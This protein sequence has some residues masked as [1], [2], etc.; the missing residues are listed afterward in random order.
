VA[1]IDLVMHAGDHRALDPA[2]RPDPAG[3]GDDR[4]ALDL[5]DHAEDE[6]EVFE[7]LGDRRE[8]DGGRAADIGED[9][10]LRHVVEDRGHA[11]ERGEDIG[12]GEMPLGDDLDRAGREGGDG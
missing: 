2:D 7:F 4:D 11:I 8:R 10:E 6:G 3:I 1:L 12:G 9:V 5:A